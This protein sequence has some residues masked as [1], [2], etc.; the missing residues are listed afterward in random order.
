MAV[1]TGNGS[2]ASPSFT[3]SSDTN[4]G[5]YAPAADNISITT[6]GT[7]AFR[8]QDN[9]N[10]KIGNPGSA[11]VNSR[12]YVVGNANAGSPVSTLDLTSDYGLLVGALNTNTI[13][14]IVGGLRFGG[15]S[16][17]ILARDRGSNQSQDL[18][19]YVKSAAGSAT[20]AMHIDQNGDVRIGGTLP[21]APRAVVNAN[22]Y[23]YNSSRFS[24]PQICVTDNSNFDTQTA[25]SAANYA[26]LSKNF[27]YSDTINFLDAVV[28]GIRGAYKITV[29]GDEASNGQYG[30]HVSEA[31]VVSSNNFTTN[32]APT[33]IIN[34][35]GLG[36]DVQWKVTGSSASA[37]VDNRTLQV[38]PQ[39]AASNF[40]TVTVEVFGR[41]S[42]GTADVTF[43]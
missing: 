14:E 36:L 35:G 26:I 43:A 7:E 4:T 33:V 3:F 18:A 19:F 16:S 21:S 34:A 29:T 11:T 13:G 10:V 17:G 40:F 20:E 1:F 31:W 25:T 32:T 9:G 41:Y 30:I 6:A 2:A 5:I 24:A 38:R 39:N 23:S 27:S 15:Y 22:G 8:V 12:L 28:C 37:N 42:L